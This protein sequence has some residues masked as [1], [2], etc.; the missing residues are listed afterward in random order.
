M[1]RV[2]YGHSGEQPSVNCIQSVQP[3]RGTDA[4]RHAA[5]CAVQAARL[6][7]GAGAKRG[8]RRGSR[9]DRPRHHRCAQRRRRPGRAPCELGHDVAEELHL[10][11]SRGL[12]P[13]VH[14]P[15]LRV[16]TGRRSSYGSTGFNLYSPTTKPLVAGMRVAH[17]MPCAVWRLALAAGGGAAM[18]AADTGRGTAFVGGAVGGESAVG[19]PVPGG[20]G[21]GIECCASSKLCSC[22]SC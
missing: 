15:G 12:K 2:R 13:G 21:G 10:F 19:L 16:E 14:I 11:E 5:E 20:G 17:C 7:R 1:Y 3:H 9:V 18:V 4:R 8:R 6:G 22:C